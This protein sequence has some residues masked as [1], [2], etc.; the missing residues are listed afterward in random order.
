MN[1]AVL[2]TGLIGMYLGLQLQKK[3]QVHFIGNPEEYHDISN[4]CARKFGGDTV[5]FSK[6]NH[7]TSISGAFENQ[8]DTLIITVKRA[9]LGDL[10][11]K[12]A[13]ALGET[14]KLTIILL[15]SG[16]DPVSQMRK[17]LHEADLKTELHFISG[18][19]SSRVV[20]IETQ[21]SI[22][23]N[24]VSLGDCYLE[25]TKQ[26]SKLAKLFNQCGIDTKL[27]VDV[28][29]MQYGKLLL[30]LNTSINAL[31]GLPLKDQLLDKNYR[32]ILANCMSE[33]LQVYDTLGI[34]PKS[35]SGVSCTILPFISWIP[36]IVLDYMLWFGMFFE[37][38]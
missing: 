38:V 23:W 15:T 19:W 25:S 17:I 27:D 18:L 7:H 30:S 3:S 1:I 24:Q 20:K 10:T 28:V 29:L 36:T 37:V 35:L 26:S 12:L 32:K 22:T 16:V 21:S 14:K 11:A 9:E 6:I 2:G 4:F 34:V 8:I 5:S 33:T 13:T 31:S